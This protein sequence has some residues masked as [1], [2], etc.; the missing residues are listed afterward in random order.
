MITFLCV[1]GECVKPNTRFEILLTNMTM[2]AKFLSDSIVEVTTSLA[3]N[4]YLKK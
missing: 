4:G 3:K 1:A 2:R